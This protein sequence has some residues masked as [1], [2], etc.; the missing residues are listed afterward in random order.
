MLFSVACAAAD[1]GPPPS[2]WVEARVE[3]AHDRLARTEGGRLIRKAIDAHGGLKAWLSAGTV[4]FRFDYAPVGKPERRMHTHQ[5]VDLWSARAVHVEQGEWADAR[6][7]WNGSEAWITPG[8]DAFPTPAR[9]WALT[10]Y[11]FLGIPWVLADPGARFER[12]PDAELEGRSHRLVKIT[13]ESGTGDSPDDYYIVY[14]D[15]ESHRVAGLRYIVA[16]PGFF[17]E[18]GHSPEKLMIY[19]SFATHQGLSVVSRIETHAWDASTQKM[20]EV[21]VHVDIDQVRFAQPI[22]AQAFEPPPEA[23]VSREIDP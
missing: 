12:L 3:D 1:A 16:Y 5:R 17:P 21:T 19:R 8:P 9:F 22:P 7:G 2:S 4:Q 11:Y 20:G 10:P 6:F 14:L 15:P 23:K 18:G 13:Y